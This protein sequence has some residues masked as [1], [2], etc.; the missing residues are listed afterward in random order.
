MNQLAQKDMGNQSVTLIDA[1]ERFHAMESKIRKMEVLLTDIQS[2]SHPGVMDLMLQYS[3]LRTA[4]SRIG[5]R[6][7][8]DAI[9]KIHI[10]DLK[11]LG[12]LE[13]LVFEFEGTLSD[14]HAE[15]A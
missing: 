14:A 13:I 8:G 10:R 5:S 6:L 12:K 11:M 1:E 15:L 7:K 2:H 4:L 3:M 9:A